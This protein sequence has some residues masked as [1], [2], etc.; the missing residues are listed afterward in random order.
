MSGSCKNKLL[1]PFNLQAVALCTSLGLRRIMQ[2]PWLRYFPVCFLFLFFLLSCF[3]L[4]FLLAGATAATCDKSRKDNRWQGTR[5]LMEPQKHEGR[6]D[7]PF[8]PQS[9]GEQGGWVHGV[10]AAVGLSVRWISL[11]PPSLLQPLVSPMG[12]N[13]IRYSMSMQTK[14]GMLSSWVELSWHPKLVQG[15]KNPA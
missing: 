6:Q 1:V 7:L 14:R 9:V 12:R 10:R 15:G 13:G 8:S 3:P 5:M 2:V 4:L 11:L